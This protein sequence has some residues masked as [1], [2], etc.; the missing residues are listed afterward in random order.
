MSGLVRVADTFLNLRG[1]FKIGPAD[2]GVHS[3]LIR[4]KNN[5]W[6]MLDSMKLE[7]S[8][9]A[10]VTSMTNGGKDM[11]AIL[12]THPFHTVRQR[13]SGNALSG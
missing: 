9:K 2:I 6:L 7:D 8:V 4:R 12:N 1:S 10:E 13:G 3:S 11:E 5:K